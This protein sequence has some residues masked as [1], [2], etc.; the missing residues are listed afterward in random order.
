MLVI[1]F[2]N[3]VSL[4]SVVKRLTNVNNTKKRNSLDFEDVLNS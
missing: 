3:V 4:N 1:P 2:L